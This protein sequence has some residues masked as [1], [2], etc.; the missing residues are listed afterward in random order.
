[1]GIITLTSDWGLKDHYAGSVRGTILKQLA[2]A[3]IVD[4]SH[5]ITPF[6]IKEAAFIVKNAYP[7]F[8]EGTVH[9]IGVNTEESDVNPHVAVS[10]HGQY[11]IGSD[12]GIFAL[13]FDEEPDQV[14][15]LNI[16]QDS[17]LFTFSTRDRFVKAAVH[18]ASGNKINELGE[19]RGK[20]TEKIL[21]KPVVDKEV[22]K[23]MVI[24]VDNYENVITNI[25]RDLFLKSRNG[26][27]FRIVFRGG[28][29]NR[30]SD[31][32][33]EVPVGEILAL[34]GTT[35]H[36]EIAMNNGTASS[37]LGLELDDPVRI[38]FVQ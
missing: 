23:G 1:M 25:T 20:L 27:K 32:Y 30:I 9:I 19:Q 4:I 37:L 10:I 3:K 29:I 18:L 2:D 6:N 34:F 33:S 7:S 35:G 17:D 36:L 21:F 13:I 11:F 8:P 5:D 38:E 15:E 31:S 16:P 26:R 22:I 12:N 24:Y 14:I 28:E